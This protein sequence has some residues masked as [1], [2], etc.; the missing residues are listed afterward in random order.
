MNVAVIGLGKMGLP[1][2]AYYAHRGATVVGIDVD[3]EKVETISRG[4]SGCRC[5]LMAH[6]LGP[7]AD[8]GDRGT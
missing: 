8:T 7:G 4:I 2:A 6:Q 5:M 1:V 3:A